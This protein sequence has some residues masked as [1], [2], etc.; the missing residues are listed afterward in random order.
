M[1]SISTQTDPLEGHSDVMTEIFR[2]K[3][4]PMVDDRARLDQENEMLRS[5]SERDQVWIKRMGK[6]IRGLRVQRRGD[7]EYYIDQNNR[8]WSKYR[9]WR[10]RHSIVK[11]R[12][13]E[14]RRL[15]LMTAAGRSD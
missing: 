7:E 13:H 3:I 12:L 14:L 1:P 8:L 9:L 5:Q 2:H 11:H 15:T 6:D 10:E 4:F